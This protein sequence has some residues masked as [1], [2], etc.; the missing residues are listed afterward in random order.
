MRHLLPVVLGA[1][2]GVVG[3]YFFVLIAGGPCSAAFQLYVEPLDALL[4]LRPTERLPSFYPHSEQ[5][6]CMGWPSPWET[7]ITLWV[8][9]LIA[10]GLAGSLASR[11]GSRPSLVRAAVA[12]LLVAIYFLAAQYWRLSSYLSLAN[13]SPD[14]TNVVAVGGI[15]LT[16]ACV[17]G[18]IGCRLSSRSH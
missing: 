1:L 17:A 14:T 16:L 3:V 10:F 15:V 8:P 12:S 11:L 5:N 6:P 18:F 4:G 7:W 13:E 9:V 2:L